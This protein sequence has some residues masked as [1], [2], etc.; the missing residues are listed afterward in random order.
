M[1]SVATGAAESMKSITYSGKVDG[2]ITEIEVLAWEILGLNVPRS[3]TRRET[4][5][6]AR[7]IC[8]GW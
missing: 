6:I 2:L 3:L 7:C 4:K 5:I 8:S 1:F